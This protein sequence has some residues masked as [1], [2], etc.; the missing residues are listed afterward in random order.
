MAAQDAEH[1]TTPRM[2]G[3][4][5]GR[6]RTATDGPEHAADQSTSKWLDIRPLIAVVGLAAFAILTWIV[7][8]GVVIP[9]DQPLLDAAHGLGQYMQAWRGLSESANLPLIAIGVAIVLWLLYKRQR[10]EAVLV[11][12]VLPS[13]PPAARWSSS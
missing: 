11:I 6:K 7:G 10:S 8:S 9:F 3:Q 12:V 2:P 1:G 4:A 13:S 5:R